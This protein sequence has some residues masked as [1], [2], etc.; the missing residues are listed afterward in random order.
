MEKVGF[1]TITMSL[2]A[3]QAILRDYVKWQLNDCTIDNSQS[4]GNH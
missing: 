4:F 2:E 1:R 3:S